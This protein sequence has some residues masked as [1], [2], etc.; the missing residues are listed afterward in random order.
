MHTKC[1]EM[2]YQQ[3]CLLQLWHSNWNHLKRKV[4]MNKTS[5][6]KLWYIITNG[7]TNK[8]Y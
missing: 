6:E 4:N 1:L 7:A 8:Y 5:A 2:W 3:S